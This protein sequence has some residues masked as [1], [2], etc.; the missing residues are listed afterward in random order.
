M[1]PMLYHTELIEKQFSK[2]ESIF[3]PKHSLRT[4]QLQ[5]ILLICNLS[6]MKAYFFHWA[7]G[8]LKDKHTLN[9]KIGSSL[10]V[11]TSTTRTICSGKY[12]WEWWRRM[13]RGEK[14]LQLATLS[15]ETLKT[16]SPKQAGTKF[17]YSPLWSLI[18]L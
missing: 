2:Q 11:F 4:Y 7:A 5:S 16:G 10:V 17:P 1:Y 13:K 12:F 15:R 8:V 18:L 14:Q 3:S 9:I 6:L